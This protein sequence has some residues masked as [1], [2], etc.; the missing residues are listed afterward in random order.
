[1]CLWKATEN[2]RVWT[3]PLPGQEHLSVRVQSAA[4][5]LRAA[6]ELQQGHLPVHLCQGVP[7]EPTLEPHQMCVRMHRDP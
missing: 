3:K 6:A 5:F 1:M 7:Q 2:S 4:V